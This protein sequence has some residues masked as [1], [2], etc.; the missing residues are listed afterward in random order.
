MK[1]IPLSTLKSDY[2]GLSKDA[3]IVLL[4]RSGKRSLQ[5][6]NILKDYGYGNVVSVSG[7]IQESQAE[8][9]K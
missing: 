2:K 8:I 1:N 6:A 3:E 5:A 9:I 4:C 7:G